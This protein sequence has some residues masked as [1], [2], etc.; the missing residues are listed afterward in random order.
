MAWKP[1]ASGK[2]QKM[3]GPQE[4]TRK[5]MGE[6]KHEQTAQSKRQPRQNP[7]QGVP[8][9]QARRNARIS[10][11]KGGSLPDNQ[12]TLDENELHQE[13]DRARD[14]ARRKRGDTGDSSDRKTH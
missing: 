10:I 9:S 8:A 13:A 14:E 5:E 12:Q 2:G 11:N 6:D 7:D 4:S 3:E 1:G